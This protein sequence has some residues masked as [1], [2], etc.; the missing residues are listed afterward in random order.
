[1]EAL[2]KTTTINTAVDALSHSV[3]G[4]LSN[5]SNALTDAL[6]LEG[7][8]IIAEEF[9][10]LKNFT[11]SKEDRSKLL[12]ASTLGGIVIA[13][14]GTTAVHSMG[15][16]LTYFKDIDHGRANGLL[17]TEFLKLVEKEKPERIK[18][19]LKAMKLTDLAELETVLM[20]LLGEKEKLTEE[21]INEFASI[22]MK[23][24]N[25]ANCIVIPAKEDLL[26]IYKTVFE[27]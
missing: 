16:S 15:Y 11:L 6:A 8:S 14:T 21:E 7:I 27:L 20:G 4:Y 9:E 10:N 23:A 1:M 22:A 12:Y 13:H 5:R 2:S 19:L 3:E 24:K 25:I 18:P 26:H 17:I